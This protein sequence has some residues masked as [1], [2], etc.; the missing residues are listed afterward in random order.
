[1]ARPQCDTPLVFLVFSF[2]FVLWPKEANHPEE[3]SAKF[4]SGFMGLKVMVVT[5]FWYT[6]FGTIIFFGQKLR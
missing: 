2:N 5:R 1:M 6:I 4:V 3:N